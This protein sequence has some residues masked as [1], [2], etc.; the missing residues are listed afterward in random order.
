MNRFILSATLCAMAAILTGC[1][2]DSS[3]TETTNNY[4]PDVVAGPTNEVN[5]VVVSDLGDGNY[6]QINM[7]TGAMT[8]VNVS[9]L[10][11]NNAVIIDISNPVIPPLPVVPE[12]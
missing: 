9:N 4:P 2:G 5:E 1:E 12:I 3:T 11:S 6:V 8:S 10:R 7:E